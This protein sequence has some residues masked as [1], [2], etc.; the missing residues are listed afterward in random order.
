MSI[1]VRM[2]LMLLHQMR[3]VKG[4]PGRYG[5]PEK[6]GVTLNLKHPQGKAMFLDMVKQ[7]DVTT[8]AST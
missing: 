2:H 4:D 5:R 7:A 8:R 1:V 3:S 6:K